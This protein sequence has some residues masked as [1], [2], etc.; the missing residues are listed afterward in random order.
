MDNRSRNFDELQELADRLN[1]LIYNRVEIKDKDG[2]YAFSRILKT[3]EAEICDNLLTAKLKELDKK[4]KD[5][6]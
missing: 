1:R 4:D 6:E 2:A 3:V 5:N